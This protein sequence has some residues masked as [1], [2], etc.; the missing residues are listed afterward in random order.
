MSATYTTTH[1]NARYL[2]H[3]ATPGIKPASSM[4]LV[5]FISAEPQWELQHWL[6]PI[7][8]LCP[9]TPSFP[10]HWQINLIEDWNLFDRFVPTFEQ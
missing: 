10:L 3:Q 2:T 5:R 9:P 7:V 6:I 4:M 8:T 1:G